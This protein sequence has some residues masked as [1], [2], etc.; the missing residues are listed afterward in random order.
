MPLWDELFGEDEAKVLQEGLASTEG[1]ADALVAQAVNQ[2]IDRLNGV[3]DLD[4]LLRDKMGNEIVAHLNRAEDVADAQAALIRSAMGLA[5]EGAE[6]ASAGRLDSL[7]A[8]GATDPDCDFTDPN[9][10]CFDPGGCPPGTVPIGPGH[11]QCVDPTDPRVTDSEGGGGHSGMDDNG[12]GGN[13]G[14]DTGE[15]VFVNAERQ[16]WK[17]PD[18]SE[19]RA[20]R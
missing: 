9:G 17:L 2:V 16:A 4:N 3:I 19:P 10:P 7:T 14:D 5:V 8:P 20:P 6:V 11:G 1:L 18:I 15:D 13:V 12:G